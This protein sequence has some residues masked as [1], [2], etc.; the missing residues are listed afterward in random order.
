M[1]TAAGGRRGREQILVCL[2]TLKDGGRGTMFCYTQLCMVAPIG[3][4]GGIQPC[5]RPAA[6]QRASRER[7][8]APGS[9]T[10]L[11]GAAGAGWTPPGQRVVAGTG[12]PWAAKPP[13]LCPRPRHQQGQGCPLLPLHFAS[14][15]HAG[16][17]ASQQELT[18]R[19]PHAW[20]PCPGK[21]FPGIS[22]QLP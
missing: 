8:L 3:C 2:S 6:P 15:E 9:S 20:L 21:S 7:A 16:G 22:L 17:S 10:E 14:T 19:S 11:H 1:E 12:H 5:S 4:R 18:L 13:G